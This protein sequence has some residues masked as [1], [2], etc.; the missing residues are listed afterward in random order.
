M[1][2]KQFVFAITLLL[3]SS[4]AQSAELPHAAPGS[5]GFS[6]ERL[7]R[8]SAVLQAGVE[9]SEI[10]GYVALVARRGKVVFV[11]VQGEQ[12]PN[13]SVAMS[14]DSIFR[15]YSMTK[16]ITSVAALVLV[17]EGKINL[18]DPIH[19]YLPE[20]SGLTVIGHDGQDATNAAPITVLDL[21]RHTSGL[22]YAFLKPYLNDSPLEQMYL[23]GGI[24][25]LEINNAELVTRLSRLPLKYEPGSTWFY[26][27]STDVLG[28]LIEVVSGVTLETFFQ[29]RILGPLG[30]KDT[31][32]RV[33]QGK[34]D[35]L[36]QPFARDREGL[37]LPYTD[38]LG[39]VLFEAGGQGLTSTVRDYARFLQMLLNK[40][41]LDGVRIL[42]RKTVELMTMDHVGDAVDRGPLFLP[43]QSHGFGLGVAVRTTGVRAPVMLNSMIGSVGEYFWAGYAGT[44]FWVDPQEDLFGI[45]MMQSVA[46]LSN[47]AQKFKRHVLYSLVD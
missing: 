2:C 1:R 33:V 21:L 46:N 6:P 44:Y 15:I 9:T 13:K 3:T 24:N 23:D 19:M 40:G 28:R 42:G 29:Q 34:A 45:Y 14:D 10:P 36:A 11:D 12:D 26:G 27:R 18:G 47:Y 41:E 31:S 16:P 25:D 20:L 7:A 5:V 4:Y 30:M 39:G 17:E 43:G 32:F 37:I 8:L 38:P 22:T 35:R